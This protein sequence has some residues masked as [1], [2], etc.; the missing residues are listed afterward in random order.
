M[1]A[2]A[3]KDGDGKDKKEDVDGMTRLMTPANISAAPIEPIVSVLD[4]RVHART[5][6]VI[7]KEDVNEVDK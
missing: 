3:G 4:V 5:L 6:G 2:A 7:L 1:S